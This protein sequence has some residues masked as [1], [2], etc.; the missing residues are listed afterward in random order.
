M[1]KLEE[2]NKVFS[3]EMID[4]M[5][6]WLA[7]ESRSVE[8]RIEQDSILNRQETKVQV[9]CWDNEILEGFSPESPKDF[10]T[11]DQMHKRAIEKA[12]LAYEMK[13]RKIRRVA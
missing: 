6:R 13:A 10:L 7:V 9:W 4:V 8:I 11:S 2:F 5:R 1:L 12:R 3:P